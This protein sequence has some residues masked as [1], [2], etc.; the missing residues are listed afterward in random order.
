M[1]FTVITQHELPANSNIKLR[2][3]RQISL[4]ET[5]F[6]CWSSVIPDSGRKFVLAKNEDQ[7]HDLLILAVNQ[8]AL[9][10]GSTLNFEVRGLI[11]AAT[12]EDSDSFQITTQTSDGFSI[13]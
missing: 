13:D 11:N 1:K 9:N 4:N 10:G 3:P 5:A 8:Y 2:I 7:S 12:I 6:S